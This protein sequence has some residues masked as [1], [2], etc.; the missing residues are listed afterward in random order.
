MRS[1]FQFRVFPGLCASAWLLAIAFAQPA[2]A[3]SDRQ[4][5]IL[6]TQAG[7]DDGQSG[8]VLQNAP[9]IREPMVPAQPAAALTEFAPQGQPPI[10][11]SPYI[12][13]PSG[14]AAS[15]TTHRLRAA[16]AQ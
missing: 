8:V 12:A 4:P 1:V 16:P 13:L 6:D 15:G 14:D 10:I 5:L 2:L 7:I 3:G 11:V 9:L